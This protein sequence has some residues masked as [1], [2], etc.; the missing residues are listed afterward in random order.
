MV[1]IRRDGLIAA[2]TVTV[3]LITAAF[4]TE[5]L[6]LAL[7]VA[8]GILAVAG[9]TVPL[10]AIFEEERD[11]PSARAARQRPYGRAR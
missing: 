4:V 9:V 5:G 11:L 2:A 3:A 1:R 10:L 6:G 7:I 8:V